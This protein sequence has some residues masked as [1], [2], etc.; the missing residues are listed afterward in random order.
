MTTEV[1]NLSAFNNIIKSREANFYGLSISRNIANFYGII[2]AAVILSLW[3]ITLVI[4]LSI[5]VAKLQLFWIIPAIL[6]QTF[7]YAGLFITAHDA[8]HGVVFPANLKINHSIG[9]IAVFLYGLFSY[10]NLLKK[11]W[12]HHRY[13]ATHF[14]PDYH[15]LVHKSFFSWYFHFMKSYSNW[16]QLLGFALV[17]S[18]LAEWFHIPIIN[19]VLFWIIPSLLSSLQLFYF[20]TFLTHR[21]PKE[22]YTNQHR[23]TSNHLSPFWSFITCYHFGYH[24][25]H[26]EYPHLP[27]WKLPEVYQ[28]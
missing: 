11:H 23:T 14:D 9:S 16:K 10:Q 27:W 28:K 5:D 17:F 12:L 19:L 18:L 21:E 26:H 2:I 25:E 13:P 3:A 1:T 7:L 24:K 4:L 22:G 20:G 8:M 15:D 6:L